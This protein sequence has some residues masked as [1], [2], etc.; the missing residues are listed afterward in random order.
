MIHFI[1]TISSK[2]IANQVRDNTSQ[3]YCTKE[4]TA[5]DDSTATHARRT[6]FITRI[7][8]LIKV[9]IHGVLLNLCGIHHEHGH[10]LRTGMD[11]KCQP[12]AHY[13]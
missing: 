2:I 13:P 8:S 9:E 1:Y 12:G 5:T 3:D 7:I 10:A 6:S 4:E 11:Y